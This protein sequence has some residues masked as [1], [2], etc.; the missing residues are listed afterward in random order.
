VGLFLMLT[1]ALLANVFI[2]G[3][4]Y[5]GKNGNEQFNF[6]NQEKIFFLFFRMGL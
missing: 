2:I 4:F 1:F 6:E 5:R 3:Y